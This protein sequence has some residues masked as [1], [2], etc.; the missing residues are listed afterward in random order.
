MLV[1]HNKEVSFPHFS[2]DAS[3]VLSSSG[4]DDLLKSL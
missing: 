2:S 3:D 1:E 4:E